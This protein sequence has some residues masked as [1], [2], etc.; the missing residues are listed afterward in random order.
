MILHCPKCS[1]TRK[2]SDTAPAGTCPSCGIIFEKFLIQRATQPPKA[3]SRKS[4]EAIAKV[5]TNPNV[6][7]QPPKQQ[8]T[9][10]CPACGGLVAIGAK[11][12]PHCGQTDP[13]RAPMK[14]A[15]AGPLA[16]ALA[17]LFLLA[18]IIS[19]ANN[20]SPGGHSGPS[21]ITAD[22]QTAAQAAIKL[23]GYR[24]DTV[25][26]MGRLLT[27][28]GYRVTCNQ[29]RYAYEIVDEGGRWVVKID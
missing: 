20:P 25:S 8:S 22:Q 29:D 5:R 6:Q 12:C 19:I 27:K 9:S 17:G 21:P 7:P 1:Y 16:Y 10:S 14:K 13:A 23:A 26:Y 28:I 2:P 15:K 24:C 4:P 18:L 11:S 3:S